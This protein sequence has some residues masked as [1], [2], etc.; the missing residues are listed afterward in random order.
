MRESLKI[1]LILMAI[2]L[3]LM[4]GAW[5]RYRAIRQLPP[6]TVLLPAPDSPCQP[7]HDSMAVIPNRPSEPYDYEVYRRHLKRR[8]PRGVAVRKN[9][10]ANP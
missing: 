5:W 9:E 4:L 8:A 2:P 10:N 3:G 1:L 7:C 6:V